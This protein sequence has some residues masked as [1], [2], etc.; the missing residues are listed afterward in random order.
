MWTEPKLIIKKSM[1]L[2]KI[3]TFQVTP[4]PA[5]GNPIHTSTTNAREPCPLALPTS[6]LP[7]L[8][9]KETEAQPRSGKATLVHS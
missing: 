4:P 8:A 5:T 3:K 7:P 9:E 1:K 2:S 6:L